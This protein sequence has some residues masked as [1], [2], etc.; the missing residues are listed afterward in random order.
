MQEFAIVVENVEKRYGSRRVLNNV[1]LRIGRG[2][3]YSL[4]GPNGSGKTT[5]LSIV[6]GVLKPDGGRVLINGRPPD[7]PDTRLHIGYCP[8]EPA[9]YERLS[10]WD[11]I[12]FYAK[13]YGVPKEDA[14][15]RARELA[16]AIGLGEYLKVRVGKYSG[17]MMKKLSLIVSLLHDPDILVLDEPTTG[18]DPSSRREVW[19]LLLKLRK[20]G[21]TVLMATHYMDEADV[22]SDTVGIMDSGVLLA[23]DHPENLKKRYG[24]PAVVAIKLADKPMNIDIGKAVEG[25]GDRYYLDGD[26][27]KVYVEDPDVVLPKLVE[28]LY[29]RGIRVDFVKVD[30]PTLEDVFHKLTGKRLKQE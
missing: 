12:F 17:G 4:L 6:V 5:L 22:L 27:L 20:E 26:T 14:Y 15:R 24:P 21:R 30:R 2:V 9:I 8:Q 23:E 10:G 11:N 19:D 13:L 16:E 25:L 1:S 3:M 29:E 18:L 7:D 28:R